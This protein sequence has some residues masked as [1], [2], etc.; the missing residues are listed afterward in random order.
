MEHSDR[1]G[2]QTDFSQYAPTTLL[3]RE[4]ARRLLN[5]V[6]PFDPARGHLQ[7]GG[8]G[9]QLRRQGAV[10]RKLCNLDRFSKT[11]VPSLRLILV[12]CAALAAA[13]AGLARATYPGQDGPLIAF[14]RETPPCS[15]GHCK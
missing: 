1:S 4:E 12:L 15:S 13:F 9:V 2:P 3:V 8:L 7:R 14:V 10:L 5:R 6:Q 11:A